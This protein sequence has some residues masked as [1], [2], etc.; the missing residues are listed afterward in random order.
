MPG[1]VRGSGGDPAAYSIVENI[2]GYIHADNGAQIPFLVPVG[3][4]KEL[5]RFVCVYLISGYRIGA[6]FFGIFV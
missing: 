3:P 5:Q 2:A 1:G 6:L 4:E